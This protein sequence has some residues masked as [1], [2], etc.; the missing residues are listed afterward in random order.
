MNK[1]PIEYNETDFE[2]NT[3]DFF[4]GLMY[5]GQPFTGVLK[6]NNWTIE[7]KDGNANG[8]SVEYYDNGQLACDET[9]T[10]GKY[11][12]GKKWYQDGQLKFDS[13]EG[14]YWNEQGVLIQDKGSWLYDNG[15][16]KQRN[17]ENGCLYL[18]SDGSTLFQVDY[19]KDNDGKN[20]VT[21]YD[22]NLFKHYHELLI[23]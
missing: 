11:I 5:K 15:T 18:A 21:Y 13:K 16:P 23:N 8:R 20:S 14:R 9:Y 19:N 10:D 12:E 4:I 7:F 1:T 17:I 6:E 22:E 2:E 3:Y